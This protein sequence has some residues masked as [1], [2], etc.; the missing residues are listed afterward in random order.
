MKKREIVVFDFDG[1]LTIKD[2]L[3]EF[4]KFAKGKWSFYLG[5]LVLSPVLIAYILHLYPNDKAKEKMFRYFFKGMSYNQ[6]K[7]L[8]ES[9]SLQ[10][11]RI[12]NA[13]IAG[14]IESYYR[15][16]ATIYVISASITEWVSPWCEAHHVNQVLGTII[17]VSNEERLTGHFL[18]KN[19]YGKEKVNRLLSIEPDRECYHLT[20]YGDSAGDR[21]MLAFADT[22]F[23][24]R[25]SNS[26]QNTKLQEILRFGFV[27]CIAVLIQFAAYYL[28]VGYTNHNIALPLSYVISL[29]INYLLT[30]S[31][32]FHVKPNKRN[33]IGFL[34]SHAINYSLQLLFLNLFV[35]LGMSKKWVIIPVII[36]C[37][38]INFLLIRFSM[39]KL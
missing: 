32:T 13:Q 30:T 26:I 6:F 31:L 16:G 28:L 3:L 33:G 17:E 10:I 18:S 4:I 14:K 15:S 11:D 22:E 35:C 36:I 24:I 39:K 12:I 2:T 9:F 23:L 38:P 8:G 37:I 7:Q 29:I 20:A 1:T 34:G 25:K 21:E 5:L 19:C 27:G